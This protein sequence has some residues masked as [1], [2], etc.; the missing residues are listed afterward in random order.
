MS[1]RFPAAGSR[2]EDDDVINQAID[3]AKPLMAKLTFGSFVGYCSGMATQRIARATALL[4]GVTF[5]GIQ[6][7]ASAGI[8]TMDWNKLQLHCTK[9]MDVSGNG[10][11][12]GEDVKVYWKKVRTILTKNIPSAGGF[13]FGFL[14]GVRYG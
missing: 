7:A 4:I 3:K 11:F 2:A 13:S 1:K 14:Y 10:K 12:D 6:I 8:L 9:L 5:I